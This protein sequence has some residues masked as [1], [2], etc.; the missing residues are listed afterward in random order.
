[1]K[2]KMENNKQ[3]LIPPTSGS[4]ADKPELELIKERIEQL[5]CKLLPQDNPKESY[6]YLKGFYD[7]TTNF[8]QTFEKLIE[9]GAFSGTKLKVN[10]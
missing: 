8:M 5:G 4:N 3:I 6:L 10:N 7:A 1:M 2:D 9:V